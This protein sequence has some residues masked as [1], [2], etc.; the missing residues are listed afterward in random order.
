M[1]GL[2]LLQVSRQRLR[3]LRFFG[4]GPFVFRGPGL[5][6]FRPLLLPFGIL[7]ASWVL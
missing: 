4:G 2:L 1:E 7:G 3:G 6:L 5:R